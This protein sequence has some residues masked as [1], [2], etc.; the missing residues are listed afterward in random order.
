[1]ANLK[2]PPEEAVRLL[3]EK[4]DEIA[5]LCAGK[6]SFEYYEMVGW[7]SKL[8]ATID[9]IYDPAD[10][11]PEDI[12][13]LGVPGCSCRSC[14]GNGMLFEAYHAKLLDY[15]REIEGS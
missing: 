5:R 1:M 8:Y 14:G 6:A 9:R 15:I 3:S 2:V 13:L 11:H 12:R 10:M 4:A 7:C